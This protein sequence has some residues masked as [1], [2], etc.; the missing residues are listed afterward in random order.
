[1]SKKISGQAKL[2]EELEEKLGH[3]KPGA[4]DDGAAQLAPGQERFAHGEPADALSD[5]S[6]DEQLVRS[7]ENLF[8]LKIL[9]GELDVNAILRLLSWQGGKQDPELTTLV[10][11]DFLAHETRATPA[12]PGSRPQ[13]GTHFTF[14]DKMDEAYVQHLRKAG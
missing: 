10:T 1:M 12:T 8:D 9:D 11:V 14:V 6:A 7:G 5:F 4:K 2:I 13:Y 3:S